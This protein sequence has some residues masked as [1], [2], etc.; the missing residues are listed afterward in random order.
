MVTP[1]RPQEAEWPEGESNK[2]LEGKL[3]YNEK[4]HL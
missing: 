3:W 2:Q 1:G 4:I